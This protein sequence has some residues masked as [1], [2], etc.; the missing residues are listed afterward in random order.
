MSSNLNFKKILNYLLLIAPI[1]FIVGAAIVELIFA[2]YLVFFYLVIVME[3][4]HT[5]WPLK[6]VEPEEEMGPTWLPWVEARF[7]PTPGSPT[8]NAHFL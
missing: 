7:A 8:R 2:L 3:N 5:W 6:G 4:C 1:S